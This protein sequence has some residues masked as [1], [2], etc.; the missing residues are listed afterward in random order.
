MVEK[1]C[2]HIREIKNPSVLRAHNQVKR[3]SAFFPFLEKDEILTSSENRKFPPFSDGFRKAHKKRQSAFIFSRLC[4]LELV[5]RHFSSSLGS[6]NWNQILSF[7]KNTTSTRKI[8]WPQKLTGSFTHTGHFVSVALSQRK[9]IHSLGIDSETIFSEKRAKALLKK[10]ASLEEIKSLT[11]KGLSYS[12]AMSVVFS[13]KESVFKCLNPLLGYF[14]GFKDI[15]LQFQ[16][17]L[18][19]RRGEFWIE[20]VGPQFYKKNFNMTTLEKWKQLAKGDY[21][22]SKPFVHTAYV[23]TKEVEPKDI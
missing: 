9:H 6:S 13:S 19:C 14:F 17:D 4:L 20:K 7:P 15:E 23:F 12:E 1:T 21:Q 2:S 18:S 8:N 22:I 5:K 10:V 16:P 11:E 3:I